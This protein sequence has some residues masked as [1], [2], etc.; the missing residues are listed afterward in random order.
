M[1]TEMTSSETRYAVQE[2]GKAVEQFFTQ[3]NL[4]AWLSVGLIGVPVINGGIDATLKLVTGSP[5]LLWQID[6]FNGYLLALV[7][8]TIAGLVHVGAVLDHVGRLRAGRAVASGALAQTE[9]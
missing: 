9:L 7:L 6:N 2:L 3:F 8:F 4:F 1:T 5:P